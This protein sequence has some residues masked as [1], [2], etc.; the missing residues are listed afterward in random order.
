ML[1]PSSSVCAAVSPAGPRSSHRTRI[2]PSFPRVSVSAWH[3]Q[4]NDW[5]KLTA[6]L[7]RTQQRLV[8]AHH[9]AGVVKLPAVVRRGEECDKV[10]LGKELVTIL[11]DL[12]RTANEVHVVLL[13]EPRDDVGPEGKGHA[14]VILAPPCDVFVRVRPEQ[15]AQEP[16][17]EAA[18]V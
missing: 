16:C 7:E 4:A 12:V 9:R 1:G 13:Q 17:A 6:H 2:L 10:P 11:D 5:K 8:D 18:S 14:A 15:V 3:Q